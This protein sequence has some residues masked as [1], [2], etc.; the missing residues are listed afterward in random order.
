MTGHHSNDR[1]RTAVS[2]KWGAQGMMMLEYQLVGEE[3]KR[4]DLEIYYPVAKKGIN[5]NQNEDVKRLKAEGNRVIR[6]VFCAIAELF[7]DVDGMVRFSYDVRDED[8]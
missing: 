8:V 3:T 4:G 7:K 5:K 2:N 1:F 6:E